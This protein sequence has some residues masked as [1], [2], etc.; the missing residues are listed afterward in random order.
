[1]TFNRIIAVFTSLT[2]L[3]S[4][5]GC[6]QVAEAEQI[7]LPVL[8]CRKIIIEQGSGFK[9]DEYCEITPADSVVS[10]IKEPDTEEIGVHT[11]SLLVSDGLHNNFIIKNIE[12]EIVETIPDCPEN[13]AWDDESKS[14]KCGDGYTDTDKED[15]VACE[16]IPACEIGYKYDENTNTCVKKTG[17]SS[18]G[19]VRPG[20][21]GSS[22][23]SAGSSGGSTSDDSAGSTG[24]GTSESYTIDYEDYQP[25]NGDYDVTITDNNTGES[26]T[27]TTENPPA[28]GASDDE[29]F[30]WINEQLP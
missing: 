21:S 17:S 15:S 16:I 5:S 22:A 18:G 23:N 7:P 1:M 26:T 8:E 11:L 14:C 25:S 28:P 10:F 3:M 29:F 2:L 6:A 30:D 19:T 24:G 27:V 4:V 9:I 20:S 12:Y 13:S